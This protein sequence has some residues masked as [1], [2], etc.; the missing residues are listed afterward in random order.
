LI[1]QLIARRTIFRTPY[2][3]LFVSNPNPGELCVQSL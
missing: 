1:K 3:L 2:S